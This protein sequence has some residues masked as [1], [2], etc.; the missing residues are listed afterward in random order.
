MRKNARFLRIY[1]KRIY[2]ERGKLKKGKNP[3]FSSEKTQ[4]L[5]ETENIKVSFSRFFI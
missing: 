2:K 4:I 5:R 1:T 3:L